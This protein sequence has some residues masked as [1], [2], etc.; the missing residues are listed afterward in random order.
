MPITNVCIVKNQDEWTVAAVPVLQDN[1]V[2]VVSFG[3]DAIVIDAG[4]AEPVVEYLEQH[5]FCLHDVLLTHQHADHTR[6][7]RQ[8][9]PFVTNADG[10]SPG[11]VERIPLPGHTSADCGYFFPAA[12]VICTGDC[13]INGACGRVLGGSLEDLYQSLQRIKALPSDTVILGGHDYLLDNMRFGL[14]VAPHNTA[15]SDRLDLYA[16]DPAKA[17]FKTLKEEI[18]SNVFLQA[19]S[20]SEFCGLRKAKDQF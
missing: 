9:K 20:Y 10:H 13:L 15:I 5:G 16:Y 18:Q 6:G 7:Y 11:P 17:I 4:E 1:F 8:L 14:S 3:K 19:R 2:Y 12:G